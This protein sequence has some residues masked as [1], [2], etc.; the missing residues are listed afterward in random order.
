MINEQ[1]IIDVKKRKI[2]KKERM[3]RLIDKL[4]SD[5]AQFFILIKKLAWK[6]HTIFHIVREFP[7][8]SSFLGIES[9]GAVIILVLMSKLDLISM[10]N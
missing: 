7:L 1:V 9:Y 3:F 4:I 10:M 5:N 2:T 6:K 8:I